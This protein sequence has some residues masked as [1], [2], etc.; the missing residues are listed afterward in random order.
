LLEVERVLVVHLGAELVPFALAFGFG[1][2]LQ[3]GG[4]D[5]LL[6]FLWRLAETV[7][8]AWS[9]FEL[10]GGLRSPAECVF[11]RIRELRCRPLRERICPSFST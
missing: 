2:G 5:Q 6:D 8:H 9:L 3:F 7:S 11:S 10:C 1:L 4:L